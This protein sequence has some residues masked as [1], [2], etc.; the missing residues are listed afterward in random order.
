[1]SLDTN[2]RHISRIGYDLCRIVYQ[3]LHELK[4]VLLT[5]VLTQVS[6][7]CDKF[8]AVIPKSEHCSIMP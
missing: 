7:L 3:R 6:C 4:E 2:E 8:G 5:L 1:M